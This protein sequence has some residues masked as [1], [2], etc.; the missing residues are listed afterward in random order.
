MTGWA[1]HWPGPPVRPMGRLAAVRL[2]LTGPC[3][4]HA[5]L[6]AEREQVI[7]E[8]RA[9]AITQGFGDLWLEKVMIETRR[10]QSEAEA[11]ARDDAFGGLLRSLRDLDLNAARL[12]DLA[13]EFAE[14]GIRLPAEL[15]TGDEPF[16]P[17]SPEVLRACLEDVKEL[18]LE[19]LL[20]Q[21][22]A[23]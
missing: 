17:A 2:R 7:N 4:M 23:Q 3:A 18:L 12:A 15:R 19:R 1:G 10:A 6:R 13:G 5:R 14:L 16:D 21:G 22:D 9:L 8:C 11:L 20:S